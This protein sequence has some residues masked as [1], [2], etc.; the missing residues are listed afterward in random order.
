M[1]VR[2]PRGDL[3]KLARWPAVGARVMGLLIA[4]VT[5]NC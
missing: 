2:E 3:G 5:E 4:D 1:S